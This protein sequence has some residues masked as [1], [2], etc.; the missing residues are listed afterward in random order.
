M[1]RANAAAQ[2][3]QFFGTKVNY[4]Y[5]SS[6]QYG[7]SSGEDD[8]VSAFTNVMASKMI[9]G[10]TLEDLYYEKVK[11]A[12]VNG[13]VR[14]GYNVYALYSIGKTSFEKIADES[15]SEV[16]EKFKSS[17]AYETMKARREALLKELDELL[18]R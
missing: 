14:V 17:G 5:T 11:Y 15:I 6:Y 13:V 12:D 2:V 1:A 9:K 7:T 3:A 4:S 16:D 8:Y 10:L 18:G